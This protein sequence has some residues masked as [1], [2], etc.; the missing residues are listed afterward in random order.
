LQNLRGLLEVLPEQRK[1]LLPLIEEEFPGISLDHA[2]DASSQHEPLVIPS[3]FYTR[4]LHT[5]AYTPRQLR[6]TSLTELILQ[7]A[8]EQLDPYR[9]GMAIMIARC[10]PPSSQ[11]KVRSVRE[12]R[13]QGT[14]P[15]PNDLDRYGIFL[16]A[17]SLAGSAIISGHLMMNQQLSQRDTLAAGYQGRWEESA[18]AAPILDAGRIAGALLVSSALPSYFLPTRTT[19]IE[20]YAELMAVAF[21]SEEFYDPECIELR[22]M[23]TEERQRPYLARFRQ[24]VNEFLQEA[25]RKQQSLSFA[26]AELAVWQQLEAEL[27]ELDFS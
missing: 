21:A 26:Q 4:V 6:F 13:G 14:A 22:V 3:Q 27:L 11:R 5:K 19:L 18:V 8:L 17:E 25:A 2:Q 15:W 20:Q 16:G 9:E 24:R 10:M 12:S 23:P 7:Q 1:D